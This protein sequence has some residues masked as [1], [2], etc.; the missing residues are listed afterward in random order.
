MFALSE[1]ETCTKWLDMLK[2]YAILY[3]SLKNYLLIRF[4]TDWLQK[5]IVLIYLIKGKAKPRSQ[6]EIDKPDIF[7]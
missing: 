1:F 3:T 7:L 6:C 2:N 4:A 5:Y